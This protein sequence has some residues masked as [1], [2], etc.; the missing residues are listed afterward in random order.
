[1]FIPYLTL[2]ENDAWN[3][4]ETAAVDCMEMTRSNNG[5]RL[6]VEYPNI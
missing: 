1:M 4:L 2:L 3:V 6:L 5:N